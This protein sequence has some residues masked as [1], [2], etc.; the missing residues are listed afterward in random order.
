MD[1]ALFEKEV[2]LGNCNW[3]A[4]KSCIPQWT[5]TVCGANTLEMDIS[6]EQKSKILKWIDDGDIIGVF[7]Y[8]TGLP[9][10]VL[11]N[12]WNRKKKKQ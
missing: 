7:P 11:A 12:K 1:I 3:H 9:R 8:V 6:E 5:K 2:K 10:L 4:R